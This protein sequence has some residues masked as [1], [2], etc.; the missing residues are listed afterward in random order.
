MT[1][2]QDSKGGPSAPDDDSP[3][4][5]FVRPPGS[6]RPFVIAQLGQSLD[7]RIATVSG[8]SRWINRSD[9]LTHLHRIRAA[10]DGVLIGVGTLVADDPQL[11]VRRVPGRNPARIVLDPRGRAPLDAKCFRDDGARRILIRAEA[12]P[13]P[14]GAEEVIVPAEAAGGIAPAAILH[15]LGEIGLERVLVEGGA[16][17]ISGFIDADVVDRL[18]LLVGQMIIG[19]G[20][21]GLDLT[22]RPR[23]RDVLRPRVRVHALSDGDVLFDCDFRAE[24]ELESV[25]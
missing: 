3:L 17:T 19:A 9:A 12:G 5:G 8:E 18:H 13:L 1:L 2:M 23:L 22:P 24:Q 7:G 21:S 25:S 20:P 15:R 6:N 10:V 16:R 4:H 11:N 14:A